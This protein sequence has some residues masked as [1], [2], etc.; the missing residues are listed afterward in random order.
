MQVICRFR[1]RFHGEIV[2][3]DL[4]VNPSATSEQLIYAATSRIPER[5]LPLPWPPLQGIDEASLRT[6]AL[7]KMKYMIGARSSFKHFHGGAVNTMIDEQFPERAK[8]SRTQTKTVSVEVQLNEDGQVTKTFTVP[9]EGAFPVSLL[10][11]PKTGRH[12]Y[13]NAMIVMSIQRFLEAND[14]EFH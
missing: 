12:E 5:D 8:I 6:I 11:D 1:T 4:A 2:S 9:G 13:I 3:S 7:I 14:T 10:V